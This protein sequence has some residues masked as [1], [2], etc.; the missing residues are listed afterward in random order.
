MQG[1]GSSCRFLG[2]VLLAAVLLPDVAW[3]A[4]ELHQD[5]LA[6]FR[7]TIEQ[8]DQSADGKIDR[9]ELELLVSELGLEMSDE[10]LDAI[11]DAIAP[12]SSAEGASTGELTPFA[13]TAAQYQ[14]NAESGRNSAPCANHGI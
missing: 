10:D 7:E 8:M 2:A 14:E 1:Q 5:D 11:L 4:D 6:L 9:V 13:K 12:G 3:A